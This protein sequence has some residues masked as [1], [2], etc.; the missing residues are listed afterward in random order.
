M[1][2][3]PL[4][5]FVKLRVLSFLNR[6]RLGWFFSWAFPFRYRVCVR[7]VV[8]VRRS[9]AGVRFSFVSF[10]IPESGMLLGLCISLVL[11]IASSSYLRVRF[12]FVLRGAEEIVR[13][14]T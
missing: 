6:F 5:T 12:V 2:L 7:V 9:I 11:V 8:F 1:F 13:S 4:S 10:V 14:D 3:L